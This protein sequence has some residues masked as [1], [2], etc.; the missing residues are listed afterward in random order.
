MRSQ[1]LKWKVFLGWVAETLYCMYSSV[2][3]LNS[4]DGHLF[5]M[6]TLV[7]RHLQLVPDFFYS[8]FVN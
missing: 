5:K 7:N 1:T 8:P 2:H 3:P 6:G 4:L